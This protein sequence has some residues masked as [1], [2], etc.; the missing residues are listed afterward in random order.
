MRRRLAPALTTAALV[1]V[2]AVVLAVPAHSAGPVLYKVS[3]SGTQELTWNVDGTTKGCEV[4]HG[5]GS[6]RVAFRFHDTAAVPTIATTVAKGLSFLLSIPSTATGTITGSLGESV[7]TP[8]PGSAPSDPTTVPGTGCGATKFGLRMDAEFRSNGFLYVTGPNVTQSTNPGD[9]PFPIDHNS[10]FAGSFD[11]SACGDGKQ[12]WQRS[13]GLV[14]SQGEGLLASRIALKPNAVLRPK[15]KTLLLTGKSA[16]EC[17]LPS[18]YTGGVHMAGKLT[19][20][21]T[22]KRAR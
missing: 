20:A 4:R 9:C 7:A 17:T 14:T 8:C 6:G 21:L 18:V 5:V 16:F 22:I 2:L 3:V 19:Y 13:W 11:W 10:I 1:A 12:G 15:H